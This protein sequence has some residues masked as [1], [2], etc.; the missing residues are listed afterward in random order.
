MIKISKKTGDFSALS[1]TDIRVIAVVY[2]LELQRK[3]K[4]KAND[5][6]IQLDIKTSNEEIN[7]NCDHESVQKTF[8]GL[9]IDENTHIDMGLEIGNKTDDMENTNMKFFEHTAVMDNMSLLDNESQ[10]METQI[11]DHKDF[12]GED[13]DGWINPDN[14]HKYK[15][16]NIEF[17][18]EDNR[19]KVEEDMVACITSDFAIQVNKVVNLISL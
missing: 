4:L 1:R 6:S 2:D 12:S 18:S 19:N 15:Q 3:E 17:A 16:K 7:E 5:K 11:E 9:Q 10:E 13:S 14:I 8:S